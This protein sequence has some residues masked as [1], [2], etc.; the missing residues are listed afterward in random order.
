MAQYTDNFAGGTALS[1]DPS[2]VNPLD[3]TP[4]G[5]CPHCG[6]R[7]PMPTQLDAAS[8]Q[9]AMQKAAGV[10]GPGR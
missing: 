7:M 4:S 8:Y 10:K 9:A 1:Q 5:A 2:P 3:G 6:Q